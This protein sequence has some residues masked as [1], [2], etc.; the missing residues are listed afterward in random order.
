MRI[1]CLFLALL[2][3][4]AALFCPVAARADLIGY[5]DFPSSASLGQDE[6][7]YGN[8]LKISGSSVLYTSSGKISGGLK[9]SGAG[10]LV[11]V[12][13]SMNGLPVGNNPYTMTAW[14]KPST[15]SSSNAWGIV[16]W[17]NFGTTRQ[18]CAL[19]TNGAN[20][21]SHY[22]WGADL[23]PTDAQVTAAG[24]TISNAWTHVA[25][26]FDGATRSIYLN[27][28]LLTSDSPGVNGSLS[29]NFAV[30]MTNGSEFFHGTLDEVAIW[31]TALPATQ[32]SAL[33]KQ[34]ITP[35]SGPKI[36]SFASSV[37]S[38]YE[39][40]S[41]PLSFTVDPSK[42]TGALTATISQGGNTLYTVSAASGSYTAKVPAL[43]G[44]AQ[45]LVYTLTATDAGSNVTVTSTVSINAT[46]DV[47][48]AAPQSG[49]VVTA[50]NTLPITLAGSDP[51]NAALTYAVSIP[52][53][54]GTLSAI[55]GKTC[56]YT[57]VSG[58]AGLDSFSFVANNGT[59]SSP[60]ALV[61]LAVITT[62]AAPSA[63]T[64]SNT[65]L[66]AS[67]GSGAFIGNFGSTD[68]N[69]GETHAYTLVSGTGSTD[70]TRFAVSGHQL[71]TAQSFAGLAGGSYSVRVRST[72][73]AGLFVEQ[74]FALSAVAPAAGKVV[75]NEILYNGQSNVVHDDFVELYNNTGAAVDLSGW[76][77]TTAVSYTFP[78]GTTLAAGGYVV[79]AEDPATIQSEFGV[80]ALGP[81][82]GNL[83]SDGET[84]ILQNAS[85]TKVGEVD[86]TPRFPYPV[87]ANGQGASM[88][89]INPNL[90]TTLGSSWRASIYPNKSSVNDVASPGAQN[91]QY[92]AN[93]APAVRQ[94]A[95]SPVQ[96]TAN[97][98]VTITAKVTDPDGV[99]SVQLQY[100][101]V[102]PGSFL[103]STL[104]NPIVNNLI[105]G[106]DSPLPANPAF[107][108]AA[109]W[110]T[111]PMNDDGI[112]GD[113]Q[114]GDD[115]YTATLPGQPNR[116]LIR[117]RIV[118]ADNLG[119]AIRTP[120][121]DDS[122]LNFAYF[123]YNGVPDYQ[124][125]PAATLTLLPN[126]H[127]LTRLADYNQ[128][129]AYDTSNQ[130]TGNTSSW[131]YENWEAAVVYNGT[132]YDHVLYRLHGANGR[133]YYTSKRAFRWQFNKG[134]EFQAYDN[135]GNPFSETW[136]HLV[137]ENL[138]ENRGTLTYSLNENLNFYLFQTVGIP[139]P[140]AAM[141]NFRLLDNAVEQ[142][143]AWHGDYW[144]LMFV[145]EDYEKNFLESHS[146]AKGNLYKL[147]RDGVSGVSQQ[148][149]QGPDAVSDGSDHDTIYSQLNG[150]STPAFVTAHVNMTEW[151]YYHA[152]AEAIR[153]Y[154][155]WPDGDNNGAY[156][157]DPATYTAA[158]G[159]LGQLW[160]MPSDTDATWGPTWNAG[161]DVVHNALFN[162]SGDAGGDAGTNPTLWPTYFNAIREVRDILWQS[163]QI[164][165]L[166]DQFAAIILPQQA[167]DNARW[168]N[169]P[170]DAGNYNGLI[171][172]GATSIANLVQDMKNFAFVG[173]SWPGD[174]GAT[175]P[176]RGA[177][178][179]TLQQ[180]VNGSE[181]TLPGTPTITYAG[182]ANYPLN[183]LTFTSSA[184]AG[185]A[186][187]TFASMQWRVAEV[188]DTTAPA[189]V[190]GQKQLLEWNASY[191]SGVLTAFT[192]T[193]RFPAASAKA[194]HT[195]RARVRHLDSAG[196]WS[197]WSAPVQFT[198]TAADVSGYKNSLV[199]SEFLFYAT[200]A[201]TAETQAG[202]A[203]DDFQFLEVTNV[204]TAAVDLTD[205][206]VSKGIAF[207][208]PSG[209]T[210]APGASTVVVANAAA[211]AERY[212]TS[213]NRNVAGS[214]QGSG[215]SLAHKGEEVTL[216]YG[217]TQPIID[218]TYS[219]ASPWP[220]ISSGSGYS[221][222]LIAPTTL[223]D[224]TNPANWRKSYVVGGNPG[225]PDTLTYAWWAAAY[226]GAAGNPNGTLSGNGMSNLLVYALGGNPT[227]N[228][229][230]LL[231]KSSLQSLSV[232]GAAAANY[233]TLSFRHLAD[234]QDITYHVEF[235]AD[236]KNGPWAASGTMV[237][238]VSN[239]DGTLTQTWRAAQPVS[240]A[241]TTGFARLRVTTP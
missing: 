79:V 50:L 19:R 77:L 191:D 200:A 11:P 67:L 153:H 196:R 9:L 32:I 164:N 63:I 131:S 219:N 119:N 38:A 115:T 231:P 86:Y 222:V 113:T 133:Y 214:W 103:P 149:Y 205:V 53:A 35:L 171:G 95:A 201:T 233:L 161:H 148:R 183:N 240:S 46:P 174:N 132:V 107:E 51:T 58:Y 208:F 188:T 4:L 142:A 193:F 59:Y 141:I 18:V 239:G 187:N 189:Y 8:N 55:S 108:A 16:G 52:P 56:T 220:A 114:G 100:Q 6:S 163:D 151:D 60:P 145:H 177:F 206:S 236:V 127:F 20:G 101:I 91:L 57:P 84:L 162:D 156:Y 97:A 135:D 47:P 230:G 112:N 93:S 69:A 235:T 223:P 44:T 215:Q 28:T 30:G 158:N 137:T 73:A 123:V 212:G 96:P 62:N 17:G 76:Q 117:Y 98:P 23:V 128:C 36:T 178:L 29:E 221:L 48:T 194:G 33:A 176:G 198:A 72:N 202:Y 43:N 150:Y 175:I 109:N 99:G 104:P 39:G 126:Y 217:G 182:T 21:F 49:L 74:A 169:A 190:P 210:L 168:K 24:V 155:Y 111:V 120:Y 5:W 121:M 232:N 216:S 89:L 234:A 157:F 3:P 179:D 42:D 225:G 102:A 192:G 147:T 12:N 140:H 238:S 22:W 129:V 94:V 166:V 203:T 172:A 146:M 160:L 122:S 65:Q 85:G 154:D 45:T 34:T 1:R 207:S 7:G 180:G 87:A 227:V 213:T 40:G 199:V 82:S 64:L 92:A 54:H 181:T 80:T 184:F 241:G 186:G 66:G 25:V 83:S 139:S 61:S 211:F 71:R 229:V 70:N 195:Y 118:V 237:S 165:P 75:I 136:A 2:L 90:D 105:V 173:G 138:W 13:S 31:N 167:A 144:G 134:Y 226:P 143:D 10:C 106:A 130:L 209:M 88:E 152:L 78:S 81:Y 110:I 15:T 224:P 204:S 170:A 124:G 14:I 26:S 37:T 116:T 159:Y 197:H 185:Q 125:T 68:P 228:N 41:V 27:G 218:F